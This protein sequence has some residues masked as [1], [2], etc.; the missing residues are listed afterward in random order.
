MLVSATGLFR[1]K[2]RGLTSVLSFL[3]IFC[4][5][6]GD[7]PCRICVHGVIS[8]D[9]SLTRKRLEHVHCVMMH[10]DTTH[11]VQFPI[12]FPRELNIKVGIPSR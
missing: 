9:M 11:F 1:Q 2:Q 7:S 3:L 8:D 6:L 5:C 10:S 4:H 12:Y